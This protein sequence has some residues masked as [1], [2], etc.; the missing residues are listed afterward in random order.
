LVA[1][2]QRETEGN[3]F[4]VSQVVR[5]LATEDRLAGPETTAD[6]GA[7]ARPPIRIPETVREVIRQ[8]LEHLTPASV[9][10]LTLAAVVGRE[11]ALNILERSSELTRGRLLEA[12]EEAETARLIAPAPHALARYTFV[13]ALVRETLYDELTTT[14]RVALHHQIGE[15]IESVYGTDSDPHLAALAHHFFQAAHGGAEEKAVTYAIRAAER[16]TQTLDY[17][18]AATHYTH[19]L[20]VLELLG[21]PER[22]RRGRLLLA[23]GESQSRAGQRDAA[24][25][26]FRQAAS[27][28]Q[29]I[30]AADI[31][32]HAALGYG[33]T[34]LTAGVVDPTLLDLLTRARAALGE[35]DSPLAARLLS[36]H[37][38]EL[39]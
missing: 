31:L 32:A 9:H 23:L 1:A 2:I 35:G 33:G 4:F 8:R 6:G 39:Y 29:T 16:A 12:L 13:H 17:E 25:E 38:M 7:A 10:V 20:Q 28:A 36:R 30:G 34:A 15:A 21:L 27:V 19:A 22:A 37:A 11:F 24:K 5:L 3:P 18:E 26:T 14:R